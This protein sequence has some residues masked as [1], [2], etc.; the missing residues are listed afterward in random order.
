MKK[1]IDLEELRKIVENKD[2][3]YTANDVQLFF[4]PLSS[5]IQQIVL[6]NPDR[7]AEEISK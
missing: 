1:Y 4:N 2:S 7:T 6:L 3:L 5:R